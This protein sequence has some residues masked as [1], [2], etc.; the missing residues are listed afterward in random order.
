MPQAFSPQEMLRCQQRLASAL[1]KTKPRCLV[2][3]SSF[4]IDQHSSKYVMVSAY[5]W[6]HGCGAGSAAKQPLPPPPPSKKNKTQTQ[7]PLGEAHREGEEALRA[8]NLP[9]FVSL[10][11][12][13]FFANFDAYDLPALMMGDRC[14]RSPLGALLGDALDGWNIGDGCS[15]TH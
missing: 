15:L 5:G 8:A 6:I 14:I 10:R 4:G 12:S 7:G 1:S 3:L 2:K 13:S 11:P 9:S